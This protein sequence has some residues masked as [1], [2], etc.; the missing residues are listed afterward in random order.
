M[1]PLVTCEHGGYRVPASY[2][3]LFP[4]AAEELASHQGY[5]I[6]AIELARRIGR[7]LGVEPQT[8]TTTRLLVDLNRSPD[9]PRLL[10]RYSRGLPQH[11]RHRLLD[12]HY[13]PHRRRV[14]ESARK[15]SAR[16][17]VVHLAVHSFTPVMDGR[18]R[19]ADFGLLYDPQRPGEREFCQLVK[20]TLREA[21]PRLRVRRNYPYL[22]TSDGLTTWLRT[23]LPDRRYLG[24]EL[25]LN[26]MHAA[27]RSMRTLIAKAFGTSIARWRSR[28]TSTSSSS[29]R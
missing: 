1:T 11:E 13:W 2:R 18:E 24:I 12:E 17:R 14:L 21:S 27:D 20:A 3:A 23:Q 28:Q 19:P 15:E 6:G 25:E 10:S 29:P 16:G 8:A 9:H 26:Q 4:D 5:D 22:G 7:T